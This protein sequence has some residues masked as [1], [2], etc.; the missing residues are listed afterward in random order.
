MTEIV[1]SVSVFLVAVLAAMSLAFAH[2]VPPGVR[3][4]MQW[5]LN[6]RP[7]WFA[8]R[9]VAL[10][11]TP[12][13]SALVLGLVVL[14]GLLPGARGQTPAL[15]VTGLCLLAAHAAHLVLA[16]RWLRSQPSA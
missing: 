2:R 6:G 3:L 5:G 10:A 9:A 1:L 11:F 12:V 14:A 13:L 4:P 8:P 15:I 7:T 16:A